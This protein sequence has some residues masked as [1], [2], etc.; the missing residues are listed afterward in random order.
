M[1]KS[2]FSRGKQLGQIAPS[3]SG[4]SLRSGNRLLER[5]HCFVRLVQMVQQKIAESAPGSGIF[6][7]VFQ[8][9][10]EG[11]FCARVIANLLHLEI[12]NCFQ[13]AGSLGSIGIDF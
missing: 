12:G 9:F 4:A 1:A 5:I 10:S 3:A 6:W 7:I 2:P 13:V 11:I 8:A